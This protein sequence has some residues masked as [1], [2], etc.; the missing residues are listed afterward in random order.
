MNDLES[1]ELLLGPQDG[2]TWEMRGK[3]KTA[4]LCPH[5]AVSLGKEATVTTHNEHR[6]KVTDS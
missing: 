3:K 6:I 2:T 1:T 4:C 5:G